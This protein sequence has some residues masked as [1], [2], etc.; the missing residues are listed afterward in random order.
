MVEPLKPHVVTAVVECEQVVRGQRGAVINISQVEVVYLL[1]VDNILQSKHIQFR[2]VPPVG[3]KW[4]DHSRRLDRI[5]IFQSYD[6]LILECKIGRS[7][8][9]VVFHAVEPITGQE[10]LNARLRGAPSMFWSYLAYF[11][12]L[13][14]IRVDHSVCIVYTDAGKVFFHTGCHAA[15]HAR[16]VEVGFTVW[17]AVAIGL[18]AEN[19]SC[20]GPYRC[21]L[22]Y[23]QLR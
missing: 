1:P 7:C 10:S 3:G 20:T 22:F 16:F 6:A 13:F 4:Y 2:N 17:Q 9:L 5:V 19:G 18:F 12:D 14:Y 21:C 11:K 23:G 8:P 15:R